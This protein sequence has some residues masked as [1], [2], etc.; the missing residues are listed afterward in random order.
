[1]TEIN[2]YN[3]DELLEQLRR[4]HAVLDK[5]GSFVF[6]HET[7]VEITGQ[8]LQQISII[9]D[10]LDKYILSHTDIRVIEKIN[11]V[12]FEIIKDSI[13]ESKTITDTEHL[14]K[15]NELVKEKMAV[16]V[17]R[18]DIQ[19]STS[20]QFQS[21]KLMKISVM[22]EDARDGMYLEWHDDGAVKIV[23][24]YENDRPTG[25]WTTFDVDGTVLSKFDHTKSE[26]DRARKERFQR[27]VD[28]FTVQI[29]EN[30]EAEM[31][32]SE[33][34]D[35]VGFGPI[36]I[37]SLAALT[38]TTLLGKTKSRKTKAANKVKKQEVA[39]EVVAPARSK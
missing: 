34:I 5:I 26:E 7:G 25:L 35:D 9:H 31:P 14:E 4:Y 19:L 28:S 29:E 8:I 3:L 30:E 22:S 10:Q 39:A 13:V 17:D 1:M 2:Q 6:P 23:G 21:G 36:V 20:T 12:I 24:K 11:S 18:K 33:A 32:P 38:L 37:G 27:L 15:F 16:A